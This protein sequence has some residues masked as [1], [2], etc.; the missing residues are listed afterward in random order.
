MTVPDPATL[1]TLLEQAPIGVLLRAQ[2][3]QVWANRTLLDL[4]GLEADQLGGSVSSAAVAERCAVL[5]GSEETFPITD[6]GGMTRWLR[7]VPSQGAANIQGWEYFLDVTREV[8]LA[9]EVDALD[10]RDHETGV[11]SR[12][13]ILAALDK[14]IAR[15]RR[16]GN[17]LSIAHLEF[18]PSDPSAPLLAAL[19]PLI[20]ELRVQLRWVD[21]VGR[22]DPTHVLLILPETDEANAA[23]LLETLQRE[24]IEPLQRS[25]ACTVTV[26]AWRKG[27]DQ[28]RLLERL[29]WP[30]DG[31]RP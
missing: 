8:E 30:T 3:H 28:R 18:R 12:R 10:M 20:Q 5:S 14:Q 21:E 2:G 24:R 1:F 31:N 13:G 17:P 25:G 6:A 16:Y 27:D 23:Q 4:V 19:V 15:T 26:T 7:R 11:L 29:G 22:L 9:R